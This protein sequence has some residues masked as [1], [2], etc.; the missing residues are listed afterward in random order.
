M[1]TRLG[2]FVWLFIYFILS[3]DFISPDLWHRFR[4]L[5]V[6]ISLFFFAIA[7]ASS[8]PPPTPPSRLVARP[9]TLS[10]RGCPLR[11]F[12]P[13]V[14]PH[15]STNELSL[16]RRNRNTSRRPFCIF[17]SS[18]CVYLVYFC[19]KRIKE[20]TH[21][22]TPLSLI[23]VLRNVLPCLTQPRANKMFGIP[24]WVAAVEESH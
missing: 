7:P 18:P 1:R 21:F 15:L 5:A 23:S 14:S 12:A 3:P 10:R 22:L 19:L 4:I 9:S 17:S 16:S 20:K 13:A 6:F 24:Q 11:L 2:L 8:P